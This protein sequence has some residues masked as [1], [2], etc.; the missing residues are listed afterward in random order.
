MRFARH[1]DT[2]L[3]GMLARCPNSAKAVITGYPTNYVDKASCCTIVVGHSWVIGAAL[4]AFEGSQRGCS[5]ARRRAQFERRRSLKAQ[6]VVAGSSLLRGSCC[7]APNLRMLLLLLLAAPGAQN[8][9]Q[10]LVPKMCSG[11]WDDG[12]FMCVCTF[13][14]PA[15]APE[16]AMLLQPA[17]RP[18]EFC[19]G[20]HP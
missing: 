16:P 8:A 17:Y 18:L 13:P 4:H 9:T 5:P 1:W 6:A 10:H 19:F 15:P 20:T 7:R 14:P 12:I 3:K 11:R 2:L